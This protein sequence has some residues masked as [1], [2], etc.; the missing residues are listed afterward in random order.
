MTDA[1]CHVFAV[2]AGN[3]IRILAAEVDYIREEERSDL[4][5]LD[6]SETY[7]TNSEM[8]IIIENL[9]EFLQC[10]NSFR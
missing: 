8:E 10:D 4:S 6:I 5:N 9:E 1:N 2:G 3:R 7:I